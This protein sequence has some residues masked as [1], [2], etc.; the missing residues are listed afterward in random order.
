ML[1]CNKVI[2][3]VKLRLLLSTVFGYGQPTIEEGKKPIRVNFQSKREG[4]Y[5]GKSGKVSGMY[6]GKFIA[7]WRQL[8]T[9]LPLPLIHIGWYHGSTPTDNP[10]L[11][12][13]NAFTLSS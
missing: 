1:F 6:C 8:Y 5:C 12:F 4:M 10:L 11:F 9:R 7:R 2:N 3:I 13:F